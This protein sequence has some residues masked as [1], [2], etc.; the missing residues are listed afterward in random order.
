MMRLPAAAKMMVLPITMLWSI[1]TH[2]DASIKFHAGTPVREVVS[3]PEFAGY[4]RLLFPANNRYWSG[5][6]LG[7]LRLTWYSEIRPA[8]TVAVVNRLRA[9]VLAKRR[10]FFDIYTEQEKQADPRKRNTGLF[11]FRGTPGARFAVCNAGGG[12]MF[13]GAIHDS[14]PHALSLSERGINAFALIYRPGAETACEDLARAIRFIFDHAKELEVNTEGYS[15]WGGSAGARMATWLGSYG[16]A[17]FGEKHLP[18]PAAVIMQYTGL[19]EWRKS[20][21]PTYAICGDLDGIAP[22]Q[23]MKERLDAMSRAGIPTRFRLVRGLGH[24]FGIGI[25]TPAEGWLDDALKFW[26]LHAHD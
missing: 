2:A 15:L 3:A 9:D 13:V 26:L 21:S 19:S 20:D 7:S 18:R 6:S 4:G 16:T 22:W 8:S 10:V 1:H 5:D 17:S 23:V 11:F 12:F 14:F 24:G 25:G